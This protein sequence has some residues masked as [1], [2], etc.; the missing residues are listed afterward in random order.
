[1]N[2]KV[3]RGLWAALMTVAVATGS[4]ELHR[5]E[6]G[7]ASRKQASPP[8]EGLQISRQVSA[9]DRQRVMELYARGSLV[10]AEDRYRASAI[11][12][13]SPSLRELFLAH[14]L[15]VAALQEGFKPAL[16]IVEQAQERILAQVGL[17]ERKVREV[18]P[19]VEKARPKFVQPTKPYGEG[20]S[21]M[22][23]VAQG[24]TTVRT[25]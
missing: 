18:G 5:R 7:D 6:V 10:L 20:I 25:D 19:L 21:P 13:T 17:S 24:P 9:N 11:L 15:G 1:M 4:A 12:A 22:E 2:N 23:T 3:A 14:D 16:A 8:V